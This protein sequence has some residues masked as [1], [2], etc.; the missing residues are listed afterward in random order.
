MKDNQKIDL[1]AFKVILLLLQLK[2]HIV[3]VMVNPV[4]LDHFMSS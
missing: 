3:F 4:A 2:L 1:Y